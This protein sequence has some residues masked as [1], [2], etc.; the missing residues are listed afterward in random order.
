MDINSKDIL[1]SS[2]KDMDTLSN[3]KTWCI[4]SNNNYNSNLVMDIKMQDIIS[5]WINNI[6]VIKMEDRPAWDI[7]NN[8]NNSNNNSDLWAM[9]K[10]LDSHNLSNNWQAIP[11]ICS[12]I[13]HMSLSN[14]IKKIN[15][16]MWVVSILSSTLII[17]L[18][19]LYKNILDLISFFSLFIVDIYFSSF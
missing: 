4:N 13:K 15:T 14:M 6:K 8:S 11:S 16:L 17:H 10:D 2:N 7:N 3:S 18:Y 1:N 12:E 19:L 5:K 9:H